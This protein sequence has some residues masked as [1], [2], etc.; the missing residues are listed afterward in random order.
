MSNRFLF[1]QFAFEREGSRDPPRAIA[2]A[3]GGSLLR[4]A[5]R[6]LYFQE[7]RLLSLRV[8]SFNLRFAVLIFGTSPMCSRAD[9]VYI[10]AFQ[11]STSHL[12]S[13]PTSAPAFSGLRFGLFCRL[14]L[15]L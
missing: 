12:S 8:N 13:R 4:C 5:A 2:R 7:A 15:L 6:L 11:F 3:F 9:A 14:W 1:L 10:S